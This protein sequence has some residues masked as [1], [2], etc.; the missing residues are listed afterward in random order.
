MDETTQP[1]DIGADDDKPSLS[2]TLDSYNSERAHYK[3]I[4]GEFREDKDKIDKIVDDAKS[5]IFELLP[6]AR[7]MCEAL[8]RG[9][10]S[11]AIRWAATKFVLE[12]GLK[13]GEA[14]DDLSRLLKSLKK[15]TTPKKA[16]KNAEVE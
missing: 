9:A 10:E 11:E 3:M 8:M 15:P 7:D 5:G 4:E 1:R 6:D 16:K 12:F 2:E 14:D 13:G